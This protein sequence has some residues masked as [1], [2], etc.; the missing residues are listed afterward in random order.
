M[1]YIVMYSTDGKK[2]W[3]QSSK[4]LPTR[5]AAKKAMDKREFIGRPKPPHKIIKVDMRD[6]INKKKYL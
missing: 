5:A 2:T 1:A 4:P 6:P 3:K